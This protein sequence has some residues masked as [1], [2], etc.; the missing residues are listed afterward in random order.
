M[1]HSKGWFSRCGGFS[2]ATLGAGADM[3]PFR[4]PEACVVVKTTKTTVKTTVFTTRGRL[5]WATFALGKTIDFCGVLLYVQ[6]QS[7]KRVTKNIGGNG[8]HF[9]PIFFVYGRKKRSTSSQKSPSLSVVSVLGGDSLKDGADLCEDGVVGEEFLA[10]VDEQDVGLGV[11]DDIL[12]EPVSLPYSALYEVA[13]HRS[14]E[15]LLRHG[16]HY[17]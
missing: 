12:L 2:A 11:P 10:V 13:F 17:P 9:P 16:D 14:F 1:D 8:S 6:I 15:H 5:E 7:L 3:T 4:R